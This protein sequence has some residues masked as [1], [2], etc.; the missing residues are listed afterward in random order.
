MVDV[1]GKRQ[2]P[3]KL[4]HSDDVNLPPLAFGP[5][6]LNV[7]RPFRRMNLTRMPTSS[8]DVS[9]LLPP[10]HGFFASGM[11]GRIR[12]MQRTGRDP[13]PAV[14]RS[15]L[16]MPHVG[17]FS[18]GAPLDG[19]APALLRRDDQKTVSKSCLGPFANLFATHLVRLVSL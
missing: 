6:Y 5:E 10:S 9:R 13:P 18:R 3:Q 8:D 7:S 4:S 19:T 15:S 12:L 17:P 11:N 16:G 14:G 1:R 2:Y